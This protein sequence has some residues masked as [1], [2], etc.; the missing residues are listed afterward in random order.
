MNETKKYVE[1]CK[2][3]FTPEF[4][5]MLEEL[6]IPYVDS[7]HY[8]IM[9]DQTT[10]IFTERVGWNTC[11]NVLVLVI[12]LK[13]ELQAIAEI[14]VMP[15]KEKEKLKQKYYKKIKQGKQEE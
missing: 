7:E 5:R 14:N 11:D 6:V 9:L 4:E 2:H 8:N 1:I 3:P 13:S 10:K 15:K 12:Q